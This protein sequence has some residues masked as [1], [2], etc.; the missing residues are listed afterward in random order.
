MRYLSV[1]LEGLFYGLSRSES[2]VISRCYAVRGAAWTGVRTLLHK[3]NQC[4][5]PRTA[6]EQ[7]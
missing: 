2:I 5:F 6:W 1:G 3:L 4:A 7:E